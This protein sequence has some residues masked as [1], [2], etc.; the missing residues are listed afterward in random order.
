MALGSLLHHEVGGGDLVA[1]RGE[2]GIYWSQLLVTVDLILRFVY[3]PQQR[4]PGDFALGEEA[5]G[6]TA[7]EA[8]PWSTTE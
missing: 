6:E 2:A 1:A 3:Q 7:E 5:V 4:G 8:C